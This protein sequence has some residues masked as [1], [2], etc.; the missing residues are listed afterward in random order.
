MNARLYIPVFATTLFL[1]AALIFAV[2]PMFS[3]MIL[4]LLGGTPQVWN[5]AM[6]FFQVALLAGYAY[7]HASSK[8]LSIRVQSIIHIALL[9]AFFAALPF[10]IPAEWR[11][12]SNHDP[13]FWQLLLMSVTVGGPFFV[14]AASAPMLQRWFAATSHKDADNPYFLYGA[15]NLGSMGALLSYPVL[16]EP[17]LRL[18]QQSE[19][20]AIG[21][22]A[23]IFFVLCCA[24]LCW[25]PASRLP[26]NVAAPLEKILWRRRFL[27]LILA[28]VPS[29]MMLGV[30]THITTDIAAVPLLWILPLALYVGTFIIVFSRKQFVPYRI[31]GLSQGWLIA[32]LLGLQLTALP[33]FHSDPA[34]L[35]AFHLLLFFICAL[36]CH[37]DLAKTRPDAQNLTEFYLIMSLGGALGGFFNAI[38]APQFLIMP[39]EYSLA[40][41][42]CIGL[43][44][45]NDGTES[46]Q[47]TW[48]NFKDRLVA[49]KLDI[50]FSRAFGFTFITLLC[51]G[52]SFSQPSP[53]IDMICG[54][55]VFVMAGLACTRRFLFLT[56]CIVVFCFA[57]LGKSFWLTSHNKVILQDRSFF[58]VLRVSESDYFQV[59]ALI[60]GTTNH[61]IQ[62][63][64]PKLR[65]V[66]LSYYSKASPLQ[67]VFDMLETGNAPQDIGV[68]GLGIGSV[69]C[70]KKENRVFDF[71]EIDPHVV[72]IAQDPSLFTFL[73][74]CGSPYR[75]ILGDGRLT[76]QHE[77]DNKYDLILIDA[78]SSDNIPVHLLTEEAIQIYLSKLK[79]DGILVFHISN[80]YLYLEPVIAAAS[81]N[82]KVPAYARVMGDSQVRGTRIKTFASHYAVMTKNEAYINALKDQ[83]WHKAE[84]D[85]DVKSWRDD[86]SNI[87][88]VFGAYHKK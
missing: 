67:H 66:L 64:H 84:S 73:S 58:G 5:T 47:N 51:A 55:A 85:E 72:K 11:P 30:T 33:A 13:T 79:P 45:I 57:P 43:R 9:C 16:I 23:L 49:R 27:W 3:K 81:E 18:Q 31:L 19:F 71:F 77:P 41:V 4:P 68:I 35:I 12:P 76:I 14:L 63:L 37:T 75:I 20:W 7:A 36:V 56:L 83:D 17:L 88:S 44:Y 21:Y 60:H 26:E 70:F 15:S 59:R 10:G 2:Q 38:I 65:T 28:F 61:G 82:L 69:A 62:A 48:N 6:L 74:A 39:I 42:L 53:T 46:L 8:Y 1:S 29:S 52:A 86:F 32:A 34:V 80:S 40:L 87:L 54:G 24:A 25:K 50:L 22:G 78:F